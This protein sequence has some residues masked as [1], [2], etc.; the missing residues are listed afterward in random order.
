MPRLFCAML[1]AIGVFSLA[2]DRAAAAVRCVPPAVDLGEIRGGPA[3]MHRFEL[4]NDGPNLVQILDL[5]RGCGCLEPQLD[6]KLLKPGEKATL[7]LALRTAGQ[8]NGPRSWN[9]RIRYRDGDVPREELL[10]VS[11]TI[12]NEVTVRPSILALQVRE[13]LRQEIVVSDLR[14]PPLKVTA[15]HASS[16]AIR[17]T[18]QSSAAG[19]TRLQLE[20]TASA[21]PADRQDALVSVYTDDPLYSPLEL[22]IALTRAGKVT[23]TATPAEVHALV[24]AAQPTSATLV[25]LRPADG[26]RVAVESVDT[27]DPGITCTWAAGPGSGATLKVQVDRRRLGDRHEARTVRVRLAEPVEEMLTIPVV[28]DTSAAADGGSANRR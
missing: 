8:P 14:S 27:D 26:R 10:V 18:V 28:I 1:L 5:E 13:V 9:L 19:V 15:V 12:R 3:R 11:A 4:V 17:A 21:M 2:V 20:V 23:V 22:P 16:P 25:R 7:N 6:R 24:S